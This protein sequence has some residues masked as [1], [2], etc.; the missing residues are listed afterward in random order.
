MEYR[1]ST[2][3]PQGAEEGAAAIPNGSEY[4]APPVYQSKRSVF[5]ASRE[6]LDPVS[7]QAF[8]P[9]YVVKVDEIFVKLTVYV[10]IHDEF[11]HIYDL[12]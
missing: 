5:F 10:L 6:M 7:R 9:N 3:G 4:I 8:V 2:S 11:G 12:Y 1:Q